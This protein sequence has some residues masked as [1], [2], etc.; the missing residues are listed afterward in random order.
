M[1]PIAENSTHLPTYILPYPSAIAAERAGARSS[2]YGRGYVVGGSFRH[3]RVSNVPPDLAPAV[4]I[5]VGHGTL[6]AVY[7]QQARC[8]ISTS[9]LAL[10]GDEDS[11][12]CGVGN[13]P[14]CRVEWL[15]RFSAYN[16]NEQ[17]LYQTTASLSA[18]PPYP[19]DARGQP[20]AV[21]WVSIES[22]VEDAAW[23]DVVVT[24]LQVAPK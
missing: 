16:D 5:N 9:G 20:P 18:P 11:S 1:E 8:A 12:A 24:L 22:N 7:L 21:W 3:L 15:A 13:D 17:K 10:G 4:D 2:I 14:G 6:R 23:V 19:Y